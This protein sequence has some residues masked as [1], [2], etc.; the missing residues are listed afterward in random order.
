MGF[1]YGLKNCTSGY[2]IPW[3]VL[4]WSRFDLSIYNN[5]NVQKLLT[6]SQ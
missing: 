4:V 3:D 6:D 1:A 5:S 2:N